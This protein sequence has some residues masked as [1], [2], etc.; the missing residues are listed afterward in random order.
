M[1]T[2]AAILGALCVGLSVPAWA[3]RPFVTDDARLTTA[4]SCQP[5]S[6]TRIYQ[7][8]T[9]VWAL[10]ACNP[11]GNLELT[12][13][14]GRAYYDAAGREA[15]S[16]YIYQAKTLFRQLET[17]GYGWGLSAGTV[18]HPAVNP[19][20]NLHGNTYVYLPVS[21]SFAD[22]VLV[23]HLNTGWLKERVTDKNFATWG[24]GTEWN[25]SERMTW[26]VEAFGASQSSSYWQ[27]GGRFSVVPQLLQI[28]ATLGRQAGGSRDHQWIS[29]GLRFTPASLF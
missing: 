4:G 9:E 17:N 10:P 26:L 20:P 27:A 21:A 28:D 16:D 2:I 5:E 18:R 3:A 25:V 13:G 12:L 14:T 23:I 19:G 7:D 22:D 15:V 11:T 24:V 1:R 8:S 6:W 29:F